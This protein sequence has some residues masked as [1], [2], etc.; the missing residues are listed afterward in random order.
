[1]IEQLDKISWRGKYLGFIDE[2][3]PAGRITRTYL[4]KSTKT[5]EHMGNV[6]YWNHWRKYVYAPLPSTIY[7]ETCITEINEFLALVNGERRARLEG[8]QT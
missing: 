8:S 1:V 7:D 5:N 4:V 6:V 3:R 2:G